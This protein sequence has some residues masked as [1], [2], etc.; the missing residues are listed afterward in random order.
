MLSV[1]DKI[2]RVRFVEDEIE[3]F[4]WFRTLDMAETFAVM[5]KDKFICLE[6]AQKGADKK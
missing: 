2:Y 3:K 1:V 4:R 5:L 6:E